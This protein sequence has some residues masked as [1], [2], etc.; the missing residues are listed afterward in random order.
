MK[1]A[2]IIAASGKSTRMCGIDKKLFSLDEIPV[3]IRSILAFDVIKDVS[4]IIVVTNSDSISEIS[5]L[6]KKYSFRLQIRITEG[7]TTR[8]QSV[9][10]GFKKVSENCDFVAVHDGARP[11]VLGNSIQNVFADAFKNKAST[12]GVPVKDT[13]KEVD[14]GFICDTPNRSKLFITQTPQV[15][16]KRLYEKGIGNALSNNLDFTDDC[17]LIEAIGAKVFMTVGEYTN[18]KITTPEDI[19]LAKLYLQGGF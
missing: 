15:F 5:E 6:L 2:V 19:K 4:E 9:F 14:D 13:I 17:Q 16:E 8:Q 12:L 1:V 3:I 7:G 10:N 18:I 11:L